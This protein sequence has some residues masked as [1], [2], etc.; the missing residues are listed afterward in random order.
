M[1]DRRRQKQAAKY[2]SR[3]K[4]VT[5]WGTPKPFCNTPYGE[6]VSIEFFL[7]RLTDWLRLALGAFIGPLQYRHTFEQE[8]EAPKPWLRPL[9]IA[10]NDYRMLALM[11]LAPLMDVMTWDSG[12]KS[13]IAKLK[14]MV[15]RE[16]ED[17]V[18]LMTPWT[19]DECLWAGTWLMV[20]IFG[21]GLFDLSDGFPKKSDKYLPE[22]KRIREEMINAYPAHMPVF[23][24]P[25][26]W[27]EFYRKIPDRS[28]APFV[29]KDYWPE[30][31]DAIAERLG[32]LPGVG[33]TWEHARAVH[34]L[35]HAPFVIDTFMRDLVEEL[36][37]KVVSRKRRKYQQRRDDE[38]TVEEDIAD[39]KYVGDRWFYI[40][41]NVDKRGRIFS[42]HSTSTAATTSAACSGLPGG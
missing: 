40:P 13:A 8:P 34:T 31:R 6:K 14:L 24:P 30:H 12:N 2:K 15:G 20:Q 27:T 3:N 1:S 32:P 29:R 28:R 21:T 23:E 39:A 26:P 16:M 37:P 38:R 19:E 4:Q 22:L 9:I 41:R 36:G 7:P 11:G 10:F 33:T 18:G 35:E 17:H 5:R 25:P 42:L